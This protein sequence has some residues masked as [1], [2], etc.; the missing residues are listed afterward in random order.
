MN[1]E[2]RIDRSI[3]AMLRAPAGSHQA[4]GPQELSPLEE[5]SIASQ[6]QLQ[7]GGEEV[8][9]LF[10]ACG[11]RLEGSG[12]NGRRYDALVL[13][14]ST[15]RIRPN[16]QGLLIHLV[17]NACFDSFFRAARFCTFDENQPAMAL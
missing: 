10:G 11:D 17:L 4:T 7:A 3:P 12:I 5:K 15:C 13:D 6:R 8:K 16:A 1:C 14:R 2:V 9:D